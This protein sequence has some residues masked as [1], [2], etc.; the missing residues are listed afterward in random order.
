MFGTGGT[1]PK[2]LGQLVV[3]L[4]LFVAFIAY[5]LFRDVAHR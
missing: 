4:S 2:T 5:V 3:C 1:A